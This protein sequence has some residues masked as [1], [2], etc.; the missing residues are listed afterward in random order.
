MLII[1]LGPL[2]NKEKSEEFENI[3]EENKFSQGNSDLFEKFKSKEIILQGEDSSNFK[4]IIKEGEKF[5]LNQNSQNMN[6]N[7]DQIEGSKEKRLSVIEDQEKIIKS[8]DILKKQK[9]LSLK[10]SNT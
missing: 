6:E 2:N 8:H 9:D 7:N 10:Q 4:K 1:F 3:Q 5:S